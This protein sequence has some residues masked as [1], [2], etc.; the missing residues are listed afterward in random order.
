MP[1]TRIIKEEKGV[2]KRERFTQT[3]PFLNASDGNLFQNMI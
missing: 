2:E 3:A 1:M